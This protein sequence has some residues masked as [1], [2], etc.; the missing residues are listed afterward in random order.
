[1]VLQGLS[2]AS[3]VYTNTSP[4]PTQGTHL[5]PLPRAESGSGRLWVAAAAPHC[6]PI[7]HPAFVEL[8]TGP[9]NT[10]DGTWSP[11][12]PVPQAH[13]DVLEL[14]ELTVCSA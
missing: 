2:R 10:N 4:S 14:P 13:R 3:L 8:S 6:Q 5:G 9:S 7:P 12:V 1:M 11:I